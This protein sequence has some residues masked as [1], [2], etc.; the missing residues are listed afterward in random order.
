MSFFKK[1]IYYLNYIIKKIHN[2]LIVTFS[3]RFVSPRVRTSSSPVQEKSNKNR[4]GEYKFNTKDTGGFDLDS[5]T[6]K[7]NPII[8]TKIPRI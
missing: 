7:T 1:K 8:I 2:F 3:F 5:K 6:N 4:K